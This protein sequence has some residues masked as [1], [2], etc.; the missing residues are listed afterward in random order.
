MRK[1]KAWNDSSG[2]TSYVVLTGSSNVCKRVVVVDVSSFA[3][4]PQG[5]KSLWPPHRVAPRAAH[6]GTRAGLTDGRHT[7]SFS[8]FF[9]SLIQ[10]ACTLSIV[11]STIVSVQLNI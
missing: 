4:M 5:H 11:I 8:H 6:H 3:T 10:R 9:I 7:T 2:T 1:V